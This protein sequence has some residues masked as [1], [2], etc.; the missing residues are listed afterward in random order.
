MEVTSNSSFFRCNNDRLVL[1]D[2]GSPKSKEIAQICGVHI[3]QSNYESSSN[4]ISIRFVSNLGQNGR[5]FKLTYNT[6]K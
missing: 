3:D 5:G 6:G 1:L 4:V 2:G